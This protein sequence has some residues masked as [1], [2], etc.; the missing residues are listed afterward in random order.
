[1]ST[2]L[3]VTFHKVFLVVAIEMSTCK[4]RRK[5]DVVRKLFR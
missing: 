5:G 4:F 3:E 1:M 2:E